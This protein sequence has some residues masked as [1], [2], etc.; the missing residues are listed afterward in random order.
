MSNPFGSF[1]PDPLTIISY[2]ICKSLSTLPWRES[3]FIN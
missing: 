2:V 3:S 1:S